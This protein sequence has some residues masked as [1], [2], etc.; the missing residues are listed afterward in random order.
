MNKSKLILIGIVVVLLVWIWSA[1]NGM[2]SSREGVNAQWAH[3]DNAYK[4]RSDLIP[5]LVST[6]KGYAKH[7]SDVFT[8]V[9]NARAG[10]SSFKLT[11]DDLS[12]E[13]IAKY[14]ELQGNVGSALSRLM[15]V[16]ENYPE[17]KAN[18]NFIQLQDELANTENK[19]AT[20]R[21]RFNE[22]VKEYNLY[23][24]RLPNNIIA[25]MFGFEKKAYFEA[26]EVE[27]TV[28]VVAF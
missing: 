18:T 13:N 1:Y 16:R 4:R 28:P 20:E 23:I 19:I 6:V 17:L 9:A 15:M 2:I 27:R 12:A 24:L 5:N 26:S 25:G 14:N 3:V 8:N 7:E 21:G 11:A 10:A 22:K